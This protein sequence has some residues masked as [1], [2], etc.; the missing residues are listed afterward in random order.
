MRWVTRMKNSG[1][2]A[3]HKNY[4]LSLIIFLDNFTRESRPAFGSPLLIV[5][6]T[7]RC[8][9]DHHIPDVNLDLN[10]FDEFILRVHKNTY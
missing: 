10:N 7:I 4:E 3:P 8:G 6:L 9:S 1:F 5:L 2:L